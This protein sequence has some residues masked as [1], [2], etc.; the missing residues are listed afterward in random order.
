MSQHPLEK[1]L[2][3]SAVDILSAIQKGF[4]A[5]IDVKGKLAEYYCDQQL[6]K[7]KRDG[8]VSDYT[9]SDKD[10]EPDF[11]VTYK[12]KVLKIECKNIRSVEKFKNPPSYKVELQRTRNSKD[13]TNTRGYKCNEFQ[14]LATC[15]FNHTGKWEF[16][17][18]CTRNLKRRED[19]RSFLKI[20]QP[21]PFN[22][23]KPWHGTL[24]EALTEA[25]SR[26]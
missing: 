11:F 19:Q 4:R 8:V 16:L 25:V 24:L 2:N 21:V 23:E 9:W 18:I 15:L 13:G 14:V 20:M 5:I 26:S 10:G 1:H 22:A 12:G 17:Y 7:L 3:A 6:E